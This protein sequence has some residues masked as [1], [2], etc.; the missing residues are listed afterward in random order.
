MSYRTAALT[1]AGSALIALPA[2]AETRT[3]DVPAFDSI[4]VSAGIEVYYETGTAQSVSVENRKGDFE[5]II[6][7]VDDGD[8]VLK[9]P[10][11]IGWGGRRTSYTVTVSVPSL[12][13]IEA[14]SGSHIEGSGLSGDEASIDVSSG[15]HAVITNIS[16]SQIDIEVSSGSD[17]EAS[18]TCT[19]LDAEASSGA[20]LDA[21]DLKCAAVEADVS[22]GASITAHATD[23]VNADASSGGSIRIRGGATD[24]S[25]AKSSGGSISVS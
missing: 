19:E 22:S 7:E 5:D 16:A 18:G 23:R 12:S 3:Y 9:R 25:T 10:R 11:K 1:L 6:V 8:L 14:S 24:I 21:A 4:D 20:S 2:L 13:D 17:V 15:A